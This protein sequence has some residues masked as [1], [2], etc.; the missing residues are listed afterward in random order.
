MSFSPNLFLSNIRA[1]DGLAKTCRF[2]VLLPIPP[3]I[4]SFIGN[5]IIEKILNFP[6]S[7]FNDVT[8]AISSAFGKQNSDGEYSK[9]SNSSLS[10]YLALQ[11]ESAE[12][13]GKTLATADVKVYGPTFKVPYQTQYSDINLTFL[14]TN[15]FYE[16]KL[17]DRW[18]DAIHPSDTN[19]LR[20]PKSQS[21]RYMT[22]IKI[23]QYDEFIKKIFAVE[24][25][26]AFPVG[27][28]PQSL[29]WSDD[30]FHRLSVS[31]A[32]QR[33]RP[34]YDGGYDL[35]AAATSLFGSAA[36]RILPLR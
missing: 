8:D 23:I 29:S 22:N 26:D 31:F 20:F 32:Y 30:G 25:I 6:N 21:S 11:C 13:P 28:A 27:V 5:S 15:E 1:K 14:C 16:R 34:V 12:L 17:F 18:I 19:N 3:Y 33:Y 36:A 2:E 24:L 7:V 4:N 35:A 10:R 9:T